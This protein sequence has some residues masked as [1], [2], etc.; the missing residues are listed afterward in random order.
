MSDHVVLGAGP[1]STYREK[2]RR[3][4]GDWKRGSGER[5]ERREKDNC[6]DSVSSQFPVPVQ[7]SFRV[8]FLCDVPVNL[9]GLPGFA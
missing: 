8:G 4:Q 7:L 3:R 6:P 1:I 2:E 9:N 5:E